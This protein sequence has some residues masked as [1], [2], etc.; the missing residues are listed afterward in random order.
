MPPALDLAAFFKA[1]PSVAALVPADA[2][3]GLLRRSFDLPEGFAALVTKRS[4]ARKLHHHPEHLVDDDA[5]TVLFVRTQPVSVEISAP[6][7]L[8]SDG[9][10]GQV[11]VRLDVRVLLDA[12]ELEAFRDRVLGSRGELQQSALQGYFEPAII[13]AIRSTVRNLPAD[14]LADGRHQDEL[15]AAV[16]QAAQPLCFAGGLTIDDRP[17]IFFRSEGL[18]HA[19]HVEDQTARRLRE[20]RAQAEI[21]EALRVAQRQHLTD[22]EG[23]LERLKSLSEEFPGLSTP[24]L[25]RSF[26]EVQ[27][28]QMYQALLA[29]RSRQ[30]TTRWVAIVAGSEVLFF[31]PHATAEPQRRLTVDGPLGALRSGQIAGADDATLLLGAAT[32]VYVVRG[33][34]RPVAYAFSPRVTPRGGVNA[35]AASGAH[36]LGSHSEHGV[37]HWPL[38]NPSAA[39]RE[40]FGRW[41]PSAKA[42]RHVQFALGRLWCSVDDMILAAPVEALEDDDVAAVDAA[43]VEYRPGL[44]VITALCVVDEG[45]F[46][47]SAE[48]RVA[49]LAL[50]GGSPEILHAGS[51][52]PVESIVVR[53]AGGVPVLLFADTSLAVHC[54][55]LGDVFTC[56]YEAGGQTIRR[57]EFADD[58]IAATTDVRD[59]VVLWTP[60][61]PSRPAGVIAVSRLTGRSV[62]DVCLIPMSLA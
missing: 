59:R 6:E 57:A 8:T 4:G 46:V 24:E 60:D 49:R 14:A 61:E 53:P 10:L 23:T 58:L 52:R 28:G 38:G 42:I 19:R 39:P 11:T 51:R 45:I 9:Y 30:R 47:G 15:T 31:D 20:Q 18:A 12:A 56:R 50:D 22:L 33:D 13:S 32:G 35:A 36:L 3:F 55:V 26:S 1:A 5:A 44:G 7:V 40:L 54:R 62:Q 16:G 34:D 43:A 27:R 37:L 29:S 25:L 21:R 48:G 17:A 41:T 2:L